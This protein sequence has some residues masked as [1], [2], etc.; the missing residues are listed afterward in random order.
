MGQHAEHPEKEG[1]GGTWRRG[2]RGR[3]RRRGQGELEG[4]SSACPAARGVRAGH[5]GLGAAAPRAATSPTT[6]NHHPDP[7]A[8]QGRRLPQQHGR[9]FRM[10]ADGRLVARFAR[11]L[12]PPARQSRTASG[13]GRS[14]P[15]CRPV[16]SRYCG[17]CSTSRARTPAVRRTDRW[18]LRLPATGA[19][20]VRLA[21]RPARRDPAAP[22]TATR[23]LTAVAV[24]MAVCSTLCLALLMVVG[25]AQRP[26]NPLPDGWSDPGAGRRP[27]RRGG[28][29]GRHPALAV[30]TARLCP[31]CGGTPHVTRR[32][33]R[34]QPGVP[35]P[36]VAVPARRH[37]VRVRPPR[38]PGRAG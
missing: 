33:R 16:T 15:P 11:A 29:P 30:V 12:L 8:R 35:A 10:N 20:A 4:R 21:G 5:H 28:R 3:A 22:R 6:I 23:L 26:G 14:S 19:A 25:C 1:D 31:P 38:R 13:P 36:T 2:R 32:A 18:G 27:A 37:A 17:P 34:A 24:V 7:A 9:S